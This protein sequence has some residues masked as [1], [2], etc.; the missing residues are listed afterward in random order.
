MG[1]NST[2]K[3]EPNSQIADLPENAKGLILL[4][5]DGQTSPTQKFSTYVVIG[6]S[7]A[8]PNQ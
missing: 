3:D 7:L 4:S 1:N 5:E 6:Y 2:G 8:P